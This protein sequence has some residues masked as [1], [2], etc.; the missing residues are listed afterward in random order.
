VNGFSPLAIEFRHL[1]RSAA[2]PWQH[3]DPFDRLLVSQA[4][5]ED[6]AVVTRD[7][8]LAARV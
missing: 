8:V 2:L 3:R 6:L 5:E 1:V 7:E 4:I